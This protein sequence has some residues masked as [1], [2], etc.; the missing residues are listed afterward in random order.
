MVVA[1]LAD[2]GDLR[3]LALKGLVGSTPTARTITTEIW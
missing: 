2:A 3:F 1:E